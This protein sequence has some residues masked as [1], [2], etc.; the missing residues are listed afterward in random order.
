M[1]ILP[2][3]LDNFFSRS[4]GGSFQAPLGVGGLKITEYQ[5]ATLTIEAT[6]GETLYFDVSTRDFTMADG[7]PVPTDTPGPK[8]GKCK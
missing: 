1:V 6:T 7:S 5:G 2:L 4:G 3:T 8:P